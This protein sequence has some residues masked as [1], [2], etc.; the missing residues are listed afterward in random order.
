[1][2][3]VVLVG[4]LGTRLRSL[5]CDVPKPMALVKGAPFLDILLTRLLRQPEVERVVLAVGYKREVV[6]EYFGEQKAGRPVM[7]AVEEEPL[8]T[9]G[10]ILNAI[11]QTQENRSSNEVLV[12]NGDTLFEVD[13]ADMLRHHQQQGADITLALKP[14]SK[15]D[16]YGTVEMEGERITGFKEKTYCSFGNINGGVYLLARDLFERLGTEALPK[17]FSFET[18]VLECCCDRLHLSG[19]VSEGY[20]IDIGVPED[21]LRAQKEL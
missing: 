4:G 17:A 5:V 9:G 21:Y 12:I 19:F 15:F 10:G 2:D 6:R 20:F 8:G 14:M 11:V 18:D 1:M 16:R 3:A 13:V 7:Y